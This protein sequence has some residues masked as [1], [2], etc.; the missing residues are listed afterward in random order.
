MLSRLAHTSY[1]RRRLVLAVWIGLMVFMLTVGSSLAGSWATNGRLPGTDAQHAQD[2]AAREF[3]QRSGDSGRLVFADFNGHRPAVDA[4]IDQVAHVPGVAEVDPLHISSNGTIAVAPFTFADTDK[5][6]TTATANRIEDLARPLR[7]SGVQVEFGGGWFQSGKM[8]ASE[9]V[10]LLAAVVILLIAFGSVVAMGLPIV[11]AVVGI[12]IAL[13]GVGVIAN[14]VSTPDFAPEVATMIG[15][16]VGI[17]Y[18]LLIVTRYR[19]AL[20]R[21]LDP[22]RAVVEAITTAGRAVVFAGCTVVISL[23]GML[24]MGLSFL[25]GLAL[26]SSLAVGLAVLAAV[27]L[28]PAL[29]G[30][31]GHNIDRLRIGRRRRTDGG[32]WARWA[33]FVQRRPGRVAATGLV[34][35][36]VLAIP[37]ASM[38]LGTAD[39]GNDPPASTTR[40]A[41]DLVAQGFGPGTNGPI[42]AVADLHGSQDPSRLRPLLD[43]MRATP[44]VIDVSD[45]IMSQSG[46]A[47]MMVITPGTGPQDPATA[48]LLRH[49]RSNVVP[50]AT[51]GTGARVYLGSQT[52][53][54]IDFAT[55]FAAR[56]P[57]FISAV[58]VLS[59]LLLLGVFRSI[60]VPLKA[61]VMNLLSIAAAYGILVAIFQWGWLGSVLHV[62]PAPIEPWVPMMLFAIVFGLSMDYEVFLLS[63]VREHYDRTGDNR[64]A[65]ASGLAGTARVITAAALIMVCVFASF[66]LSDMRP[67]KLIGLGLAVAVAIDATLVRIMLVPATMELLGRANWWLPRWLDRLL[68]RLD[69]DGSAA[70]DE[71]ETEAAPSV[72][73]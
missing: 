2:L 17:D 32:A 68:P 40:K 36:L 8:P 1:R 7:D 56:L 20:G 10:G 19:E 47:A 55:V 35:L 41:Y 3:P 67:L 43:A 30:F 42:Y 34:V 54:D 45:P 9:A 63:S 23:L 18:A 70:I 71:G 51:T 11:T 4:Y 13:A 62:S 53:A 72:A 38:R 24:L 22:E 29:L 57:V 52:A 58:L 21:T 37:F 61:V 16:G 48:A 65:V 33:G 60:L 6:A 26:G 27:T 15:L 12:V 49:L 64:T 31:A 28:L 44:D 46:H 39:A 14:V 50:A 69:V 59:F 25:Q 5:A 73:A 66:V